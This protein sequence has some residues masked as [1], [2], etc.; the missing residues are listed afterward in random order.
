MCVEVEWRNGELDL[1]CLGA[2][3]RAAALA[4]PL[5]P[6]QQPP[7]QCMMHDQFSVICSLSNLHHLSWSVAIRARMKVLHSAMLAKH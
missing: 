6:A 7:A 2:Q 5:E 4:Q 1:L 3:L